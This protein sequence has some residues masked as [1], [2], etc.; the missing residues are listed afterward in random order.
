M[1]QTVEL[2]RRRVLGGLAMIGTASAAA[3][4]GTMALFSDKEKTQANTIRGGTIDL[5][6][7]NSGTLL[8]DANMAPGDT[9]GGPVTL[10]SDGSLTGS[11]DIAVSYTESNGNANTDDSRDVNAETF[12]KNIVISTLK[13]DGEDLSGQIETSQRGKGITLYDLAHNNLESDGS[14]IV[15][16]ADPGYGTSFIVHLTLAETVSNAF[17]NDGIDATFT[18]HLN[19]KDT[20]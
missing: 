19:Q 15:N 3:G 8:M 18:F 16:L 6:V 17:Q 1:D 12:A 9:V 11:L 14:D 2:T 4:A 10:R 13:Y 7:G 5:T 20:Q